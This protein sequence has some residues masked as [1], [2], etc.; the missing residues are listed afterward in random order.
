MCFNTITTFFN[1]AFYFFLLN[2][3]LILNRGKGNFFLPLYKLSYKVEIHNF[4]LISFNLRVTYLLF[5]IL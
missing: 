1:V 3:A 5:C 2:F 4:N